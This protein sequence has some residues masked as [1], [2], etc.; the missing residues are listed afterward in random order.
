MTVCRRCRDAGTDSDES[1]D[2]TGRTTRY[3]RNRSRCRSRFR[4][5]ADDHV[6]SDRDR[7]RAT[8]QGAARVRI[9]ER[10]TSRGRGLLTRSYHRSESLDSELDRLEIIDKRGRPRPRSPSVQVVE[11]IRY[12]QDAPHRPATRETVYI[13]ERVPAI[14]ISRYDEEHSHRD[15]DEDDNEEDDEDDDHD[16]MDRLQRFVLYPKHLV[17]ISVNL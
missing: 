4:D 12:I 6:M 8:R 7:R 10:S 17:L 11:R 5:E 14:R 9:V 1:Y 2:S 15:D 3:S 13:E 16:A